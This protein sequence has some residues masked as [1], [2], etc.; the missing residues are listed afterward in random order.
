MNPAR[1][2]ARAAEWAA[3]LVPFV[4]YAISLE[5]A[6]GFWDT[7]EAQTVPWIFGIMHPTGFPVFTIL[8]GT[9][10]HI[11]PF[12]DVSWRIAL[13][14][15]LCMSAAAWLVSRIVFELRPY[16]WIAAA[17]AW[18]F[19][20]GEVA[21][22]RGTRPEVHALAIAFAMLALYAA[23]RWY[24]RGEFAWLIAGAAA[25]GL[26]MG[27]HPLVA[28]IGPALLIVFL[29][30]APS[31]DSRA[32]FFALLAVVAGVLTYA[33][34]P[35]RSAIVTAEH[36]DPTAQLGLPPGQSFWDNEHPS[37]L[38]GFRQMI[39]GADFGAGGTFGHLIAPETYSGGGMKYALSALKEFTPFGLVLAVVG[40][41]LLLRDDLWLGITL[42]AALA[43]PTD[44]SFAYTIE[45]DPERYYLISFA[46]IAVFAGYACC[47]LADRV[48]AGRV[49]GALALAATAALLL[50]ANRDTFNQ[51]H[52][53]G[54]E[55]MIETVIA[56]TPDNAIL[57]APWLDATP[58]AYAA[59]VQHRLGHRIVHSTWL[60]DDAQYVPVWTKTRPVYVVDQLFGKVKGFHTQTIQGQPTLWRVVKN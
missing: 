31:V 57:L 1:L 15:A 44:F 4:V 3:W 10:A 53:N 34:L 22:S 47:R 26:G 35:V 51:R 8:A 32:A 39:S 23:V 14:S 7:G 52:D 20:F 42:F 59:Y 16:P 2:N 19:G 49:F 29:V 60:S 46:L 55:T 28:L 6:I 54:A 21:W 36:L 25:W 43:V 18:F 30:R 50:Y 33:Y 17:S 5:G 45:A 38:S 40:I 11:F 41:V 13:F 48:P 9:F 27:T 37:S 56:R 58:L 12:G 24:R